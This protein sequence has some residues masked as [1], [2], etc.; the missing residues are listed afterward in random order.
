LRNH[1][2]PVLASFGFVQDRIRDALCEVSINYRHSPLSAQDWPWAAG[3]AAAGDRL[4]DAPLSNP[5]GTRTTLFAALRDGRHTPLLFPHGADSGLEL[6]KT[7]EETREV[8]PDV[9]SSHFFLRVGDEPT[10]TSD[11]PVWIDT[12]G[13]VHQRLGVTGPA[14]VLARPDGYIGYRCQPADPAKLL[15]FLGRYLV[16]K[17]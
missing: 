4:P 15:N 10:L 9:L 8:F 12:E 17:G 7:G 6:V 14:L 1:I 16:R 3:G 13:R 11:V 5:A 2:A